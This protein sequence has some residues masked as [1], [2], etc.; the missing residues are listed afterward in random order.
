[1]S[2]KLTLYSV[3]IIILNN[4]GRLASR[5]NIVKTYDQQQMKKYTKDTKEGRMRLIGK[6]NMLY[7]S[8]FSIAV[9]PYLRKT[10]YKKRFILAINLYVSV[11][12]SIAALLLGL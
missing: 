8:Q 7:T 5:V 2:S 4:I 1:M 9:T 11:H 6:E 10:T 3:H 12:G